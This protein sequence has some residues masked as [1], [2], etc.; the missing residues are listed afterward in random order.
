M[1][2]R[3]QGPKAERLCPA[4]EVRPLF[5]PVFQR[6]GNPS[7]ISTSG[8]RVPPF[9]PASILEPRG[10]RWMQPPWGLEA[11]VLGWGVS[12]AQAAEPCG[13]STDGPFRAGARPCLSRKGTQS[14]AQGAGCQMDSISPVG[15]SLRPP[16]PGGQAPSVRQLFLL[17]VCLVESTCT[18]FCFL[19]SPGHL[20][21]QQGD[22]ERMGIR[23][24]SPLPARQASCSPAA[25]PRQGLASSWAAHAIFRQLLEGASPGVRSLASVCTAAPQVSTPRRWLQAQAAG[26]P[27]FL[28]PVMRRLSCHYQPSHLV[29]PCPDS[30]AECSVRDVH[31]QRGFPRPALKHQGV[32]SSPLRT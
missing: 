32:T 3:P 12:R 15:S 7:H 22:S 10:G 11:W 23:D 20:G 14:P 4:L 6:H 21:C 30:S 27:V 17:V 18:L 2:P 25:F 31:W 26:A 19:H 24:L 8:L 28:G 5:Y 29:A 9:S 16:R 13:L 1:S